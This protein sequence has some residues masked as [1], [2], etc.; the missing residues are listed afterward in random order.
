MPAQGPI[1]IKCIVRGV[2]TVDG[3]VKKFSADAMPDEVW[4]RISVAQDMAE[5]A[6]NTANT[7]TSTAQT[8][9]STAN[10]AKTTA[11][12]AMPM[13][14]GNA[15]GEISVVRDTYKCTVGANKYAA[16]GF[17]ISYIL[18]GVETEFACFTPDGIFFST[19]AHKA[20][21]SPEKIIL[22][23]DINNQICLFNEETTD[24]SPTS[25]TMRKKR[26]SEGSASEIVITTDSEIQTTAGNIEIENIG[27][28]YNTK[29]SGIIL[30]SDTLGSHKKFRISVD[31]SGTISATE[32]TT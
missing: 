20:T 7:A 15:T 6:Q 12:A 5:T 16:Y 4:S 31:D 26:I 13:T 2:S 24:Q 28:T 11:D 18:N 19:P 17:K 3:D 29:G 27:P 22:G 23:N 32:V 14:G 1:M 25:F 10:T 8:A 9:Q 30:K 21:I